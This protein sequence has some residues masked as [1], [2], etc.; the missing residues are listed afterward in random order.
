VAV[1]TAPLNVV[2]RLSGDLGTS[3]PQDPRQP[4]TVV[5]TPFYIRSH[6]YTRIRQTWHPLNWVFILRRLA[7]DRLTVIELEAPTFPLS[8]SPSGPQLPSLSRLLLSNFFSH[9]LAIKYNL[10]IFLWHKSAVGVLCIWVAVA[11][12]LS[13][14]KDGCKR[15]KIEL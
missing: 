5:H 2:D 1:R 13:V 15:R 14:N 4:N 8:P 9:W 7:D 6:L 10:L 11:I 12:S 3:R